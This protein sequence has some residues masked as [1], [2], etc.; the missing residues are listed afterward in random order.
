M[1]QKRYQVWKPIG[2]VWTDWF[3]YSDSNSPHEAERLNRDP[4]LKWQL[5]N[6]L[7]NQYRYVSTTG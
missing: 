2:L 3:H 1:I 4:E 7:R 6:K 5:K